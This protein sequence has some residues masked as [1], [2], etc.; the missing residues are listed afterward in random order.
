MKSANCETPLEEHYDKFLMCK[1]YETKD[2]KVKAVK[3]IQL[4][5]YFN[6]RLKNNSQ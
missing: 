2:H 5:K 4:K 1:N 6:L 3:P